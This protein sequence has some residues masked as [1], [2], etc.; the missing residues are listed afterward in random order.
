MLYPVIF[1]AVIFAYIVIAGFAVVPS[2]IQR[3]GRGDIIR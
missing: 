2:T 3:T 1:A